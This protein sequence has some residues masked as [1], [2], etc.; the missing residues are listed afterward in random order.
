MK[1][2]GETIKLIIKERKEPA[3]KIKELDLGGER[4]GQITPEVK[5][6]LE[7]FKNLECLVLSECD[8]S[9]LDNLPQLPHIQD[10]DLSSNNLTDSEIKKIAIYPK[11]V[12][13]NIAD[14][15]I[16]KL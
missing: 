10:L 16:S 14:N 3:E 7:K 1:G 2:I 5:T 4:I 6:L 15:K 9:S 8:I 13:L 11:L 12:S